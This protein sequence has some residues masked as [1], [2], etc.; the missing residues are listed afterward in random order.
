MRLR[1]LAYLPLL[2]L[3]ST[4]WTTDAQATSVLRVPLEELT[5]GSDLVIQAR[6][7]E[8]AVE[9]A[10]E[11]Q[12]QI[13][14][15]VRFQVIR[16]HKGHHS[17][18]FFT[19][20]L[21][22]GRTEQWTLRIPGMP[23]FSEGEEVVLFLEATSGG[24]IPAGLSEGKFTVTRNADSGTAR[25]QRNMGGMT[26]INRAADGAL[27]T[28]HAPVSYSDDNM[29]LEDLLSTVRRALGKE[30]GAR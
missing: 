17:G 28:D 19:L 3:L 22:G 24:Y 7:V 12:R 30:G 29:D 1:F 21:I 23:D 15:R 2:L 26:V 16:V 4:G 27:E 8:V 14:T 20:K 10:L 9:T 6:V 25:V 11:D 18:P 13:W 5:R